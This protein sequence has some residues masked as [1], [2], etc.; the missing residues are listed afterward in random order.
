MGPAYYMP[1]FSLPP[2]FQQSNLARLPTIK[3]C[4]IAED[5]PCLE[6]PMLGPATMIGVAG[7]FDLATINS[8]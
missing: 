4:P 8:E 6:N 5:F 3:P 1:A 2:G 7:L